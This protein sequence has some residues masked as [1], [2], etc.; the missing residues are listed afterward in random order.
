MR[1]RC[2]SSR[3]TDLPDLYIDPVAGFDRTT[4][5]PIQVGKE[6]LVYALTLRAGGVWY[7]VLD[8]TAVGYPVWQPAPLFEVSDPRTSRFWI[9]GFHDRGL[10]GGSAI[11]AFADWARHPN[12]YYDRLSDGESNA[13]KVFQQYRELMDL[14]FD[15]QA[16]DRVVEDLGDGWLLCPKCREAWRGSV[17]GAMVRCPFCSTVLRNASLGE[18]DTTSV[19]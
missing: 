5:F 16:V 13:A 9:F 1:V 8:E 12:D 10:R 17:R 7:Y 3:G 19:S 2:T 4:I 14:E 15:D 18:P 6:Y 11:F